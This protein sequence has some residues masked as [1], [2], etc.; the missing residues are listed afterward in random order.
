MENKILN[1]LFMD[2]VQSEA[3]NQVLLA[4]VEHTKLQ[5]EARA[6]HQKIL[7]GSE[8]IKENID[9]LEEAYMNLYFRKMEL[10]YVAGFWD[11]IDLLKG[12]RI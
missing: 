1:Q 9:D 12:D 11:A 3:F 5:E 8:A 6:I 4:D 2:K 7:E 10:L